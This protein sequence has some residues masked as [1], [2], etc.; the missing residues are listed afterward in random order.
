M[1]WRSW[2]LPLL[3][4]LVLA[5]STGACSSPNSVSAP[6]SKSPATFVPN[7][8]IP[9]G[10]GQA[11]PS[12]ITILP[13]PSGATIDSNA[14]PNPPTASELADPSGFVEI[15]YDLPPQ[16]TLQDLDSWYVAEAIGA[17]NLPGWDWCEAQST[18]QIGDGLSWSWQNSAQNDLGLETGSNEKGAGLAGTQTFIILSRDLSTVDTTP[19]AHNPV[20]SGGAVG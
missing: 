3:L 16:I 13:I 2:L 11:V 8:T 17:K 12:L 1:I 9:D 14:I 10:L 5:L 19:C 6:Q 15:T 20:G 4:L 7:T 18:A